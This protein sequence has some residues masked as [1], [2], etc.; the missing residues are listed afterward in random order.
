MKAKTNTEDANVSQSLDKNTEPCS[1][2]L[3]NGDQHNLENGNP[4][5]INESLPA[6][7]FAKIKAGLTTIR[8]GGKNDEHKN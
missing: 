2:L 8:K 3:S 5:V 1:S 6:D 4:E 7:T